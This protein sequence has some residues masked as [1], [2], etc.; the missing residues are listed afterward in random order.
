MARA[1]LKGTKLHDRYEP[2]QVVYLHFWV[3]TVDEAGEVEEL[4]PLREGRGAGRS[5]GTGREVEKVY[6]PDISL[7]RTAASA[8]FWSCEA[9]SESG[10]CPG[11]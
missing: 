5:E 11:E 3:V 9:S 1:P 6:V 10:T 2:A 8:S 4:G 7:S